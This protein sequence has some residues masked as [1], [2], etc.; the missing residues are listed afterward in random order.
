MTRALYRCLVQMHPAAFRRQ[1]AGE[2]LWIFE[3]A[4]ASQGMLALFLD[5]LLSLARQ[6]LLRSG[7]WK[8][9]LAIVGG[10]LEI[11]AG[12]LGGAMVSRAQFVPLL[13]ASQF[14][15]HWAGTMRVHGM[16]EP[17]ELILAKSGAT[18]TGLVRLQTRSGSTNVFTITGIAPEWPS[19]S[20]RVK[21]DYA[22]FSFQ[23]RLVPRSQGSRLQG[24]FEANRARGN[25][26]LAKREKPK[27]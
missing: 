13:A 5:G 6:W 14:T 10:L 15:G 27:Y 19:L 26:E 8:I 2:M 20:F 24:T 23:G 3:E 9:A 12:G 1:F 22:V 25:W 16:P 4:S 17:M 11:T 21:I 7:S 18:W